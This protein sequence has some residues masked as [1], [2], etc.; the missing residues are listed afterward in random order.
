[1]TIK[2]KYH[3]GIFEPLSPIK[4]MDL[5][6]G[7]EL[8]IQIL[9]RKQKKAFKGIVGLFSDLSDHEIQKFDGAA[10]RRPLFESDNVGVITDNVAHFLRIAGLEVENWLH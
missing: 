10:K 9:S 4:G 5:E 1:M 8:E 3:K 6:E 2:V 7:S